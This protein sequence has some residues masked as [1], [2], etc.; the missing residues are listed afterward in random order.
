[1]R[2]QIAMATFLFFVCC[3]ASFDH[4]YYP[5]YLDRQFHDTLV[6]IHTYRRNHTKL[7]M[8][9]DDPRSGIVSFEKGI[10]GSYK[11]NWRLKE[12]QGV[13]NNPAIFV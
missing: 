11:E 6:K 12:V 9:M 13:Q 7:Y 3:T 2:L 4:E 1:M 10:E 8:S 5:M